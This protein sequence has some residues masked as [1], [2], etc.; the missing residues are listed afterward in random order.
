MKLYILSQ[1]EPFYLPLFWH[2][3]LESL[4]EG[5]VIVGGAILPPFN[6]QSSW[7][8]VV[9]DHWRLYGWHTFLRL[10]IAF[11]YRKMLAMTTL[12]RIGKTRCTVKGVLYNHNVTCTEVTDINSEQFCRQVE[13]LGVELIL[14]VACPV[15]L[16]KQLIRTPSQG[17][18]NLHN[19]DLPDYRGINPLFRAML[20]GENKAATTV[21]RI[22][23]KIDTGEILAKKYFSIAKNDSLHDLYMKVVDHG[24]TLLHEAI[25]TLNNNSINPEKTDTSAGHY[26]G[27][28]TAQ[29]GKAF[30]R[31]GL[32]FL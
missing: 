32:R 6:G 15:V 5:H 11:C 26:Y 4:H 9:R 3:F 2:R 12:D 13:H 7:R 28:P 8:D 23:Q 1:E 17:C 25:F 24:P 30:R 22:D 10:V 20:N 27:F 31:K 18:I 16:K 21:H 19:G 29:E 14:S